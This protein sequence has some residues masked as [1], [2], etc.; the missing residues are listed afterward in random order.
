M[1]RVDIIALGGTSAASLGVTVDVLDAA[2]RLAGRKLFCWRMLGSTRIARA[3]G[4]I[5]AATEPLRKARSRDLVVIPGLGAA[6]KEE[7]VDRLAVADARAASLWLEQAR[8]R[9]SVVAAS[10]TGVF[11]L[12]RAGLL[13]G[14]HCTTTWWLITALSALFPRCHPSVDSMVMSDDAVWTAGASLAHIDLMLALVAHFASPALADEVARYMIVDQRSSQARFVVPTH[15]ASR[16]PLVRQVEMFVRGRIKRQIRLD[17]IAE[18]VAIVPRT[19]SRRLADATGLSPMRFVQKVRLD[20]ALHLLQTTRV[21]LDKIAEEVGFAEQSALY[22]LILRHTG[23]TPSSLRLRR[24]RTT[25]N[26][27]RSGGSERRAHAA[28]RIASR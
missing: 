21:S 23:Q 14:R 4:G 26:R 3:R 20:A 27:Q 24:K 9:G 28:H 5:S 15:L 13:D 18:A 16:D 1:I 2:N 10:C 17:E 22:R 6:T 8:R 12:G 19:L 25:A 11:L 7:I